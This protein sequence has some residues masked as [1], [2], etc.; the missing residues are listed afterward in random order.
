MALIAAAFAV[1]LAAQA[2]ALALRLPGLHLFPKASPPAFAALPGLLAIA[3]AGLAWWWGGPWPCAGGALLGLF[4]A[5]LLPTARP[6]SPDA[7]LLENA[8]ALEVA[9][10]PDAKAVVL[11][12]QGTPRAVVVVCH[13]GGNDRTFALWHAVPRLVGR[14][15][16]V[17]L[18]HLPGHG[19]GGTDLLDLASFRA[20]FD[21]VCEAAARVARGH[22]RTRTDTDAHGPG[23]IAGSA[24]DP[25][26]VEVRVGPCPSVPLVALG[27]SL[28][29]ALVL[30][31]LCRGV[32]LD[33]AVTVSAITRLELGPRIARELFM[34]AH[35]PAWNAVR[36][37][38]VL[39]LLPLPGSRNRERYPVR[40]AAGEGHLEVFDRVLRSLDLEQRLARATVKCPLL[41][42]HGTDDAVVPV[43]QGRGL[44]KAL[45][46]RA[47]YLELPG[48][49][50]LDPL[51]DAA[52]ADRICDFVDAAAASRRS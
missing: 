6:L 49:H 22:G 7:D 45:R 14:G 33:A 29:G 20:R 47:T 40:V 18:F 39:R 41:L 28:G 50:H 32:P 13:G 31:A 8:T 36:Y 2:A 30:D 48:R 34:V 21:A 38:S 25:S 10:H 43:E 17:V 19:R 15:F 12:P 11:R 27:Q 26:S 16:A 46:E 3:T 5:P 44:A 37:D 51:F 4:V 23:P 35:A 1:V 24:G 52:L 42:V 9:G